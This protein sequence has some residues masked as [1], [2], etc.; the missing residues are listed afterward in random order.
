M[1]LGRG[2]RAAGTSGTGAAGGQLIRF[3]CQ[4]GSEALKI[5]GITSA[6]GELQFEENEY[7]GRSMAIRR[8]CRR[9]SA[10]TA[11]FVSRVRS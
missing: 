4:L 8:T 1:H 11:A 2:A 10:V 7:D 3:E 5:G 9:A 6:T